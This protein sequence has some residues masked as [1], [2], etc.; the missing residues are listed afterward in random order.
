VSMSAQAFQTLLAL[1]VVSAGAAV[2]RSRIGD[3]P[4][5][6]LEGQRGK[7]AVWVPTPPGLVEAMLDLAG[8]TPEDYVIDLG[9]GDGRMVIAAAQRG[10]SALGVEY[11]DELVEFSKRA[12]AAAGVQ[13]RASFVQGDLYEVDFSAATVLTLFLLPEILAA[14]GPKLAALQPGTRIVTN[15]FGIEGWQSDSI[16]RIG[17]NTPTCCTALLYVVRDR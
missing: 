1:C 12:A 8:V 3:A 4:F 13:D 11:S 10:A 2:A 9:S 15:R 14:L 6:P 7:D 16:V 5:E 17:G